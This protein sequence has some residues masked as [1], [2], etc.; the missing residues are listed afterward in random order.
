ME[1]QE[2]RELREAYTRKCMV[3]RSQATQEWVEGSETRL[4]SPG[5]TVK[6]HECAASHER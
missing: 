4:W 5:R 3:I 1:K 2:P 6:A